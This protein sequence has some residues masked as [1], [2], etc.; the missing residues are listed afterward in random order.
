MC[1]IE[2]GKRGKNVLVLDHA[3]KAGKKILM[4]GGGRCNFTN[5]HISADNYLSQNPHF[6]KS[7][8]KQYTQWDF[9]DLVEQHHIPYHE[10][11]HGQLF[12][13]DSAKD[14]LN[15]LLAEC[16]K[17]NVTIKLNC[18]IENITQDPSN[19][20]ITQTNQGIFY[21]KA[22]VVAT[23]GL[24]IPKM[25]ASPLGYQLAEQFGHH[26]WPTSAGLVPFTL[27]EH[28]KQAL[29]ELSGVSVEST[30][31]N[32][33]IQFKESTLFTHRGLSGPAM[34]QISS[35]WQAGEAITLQLLPELNLLEHL[36]HLKDTE[37]NT[38]LK[39]LLTNLL[40]KRLVPILFE[41]QLLDKSLQ[42]ISKDEL[43]NISHTLQAWEIKPNGTEG[44]RTIVFR[45][46]NIINLII[47]IIIFYS[48]IM[49]LRLNL[50]YI[51]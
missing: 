19:T 48:I 37:P 49:Y 45:T 9:I 31:S 23:G 3:N 26:I 40:P 44:Y 17:T 1:A 15:M 18:I 38:N 14:I 30:V 13:I 42:E 41:R 29:A 25:C 12:C 32:E 20:F 39:N 36:T 51:Y 21:S 24:S 16:D 4:S 22:L 50:R 5:L 11:K 8:L 43:K 10:K 33:H 28:D 34:L 27:H 47:S 7:A 6:C 2:A 35:Y 46:H